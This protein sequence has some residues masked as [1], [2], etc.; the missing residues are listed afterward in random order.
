ME[1][2]HH[3]RIL[4]RWMPARQ[5]RRCRWRPQKRTAR[6]TGAVRYKQHG[7]MLLSGGVLYRGCT[8]P[9]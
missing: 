1:I 9:V 5:L 7:T 3:L 4:G 8:D 2:H 6:K